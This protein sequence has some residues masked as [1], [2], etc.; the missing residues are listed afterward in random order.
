MTSINLPTLQ[1]NATKSPE[2]LV[3]LLCN[4]TTPEEGSKQLLQIGCGDLEGFQM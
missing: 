2:L 1:E 4:V 3:M